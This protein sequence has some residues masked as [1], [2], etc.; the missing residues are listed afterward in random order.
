MTHELSSIE[1]MAALPWTY[2]LS[3]DDGDWVVTIAELPDFFAA[4]AT[5]GEAVGNAQ[6]AL[7]SHLGGYIACGREIPTPPFRTEFPVT[8]GD[9]ELVA[10]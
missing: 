2:D 9:R 1:A 8:S 7:L 5:P 3:L 6:E 10:A 4:G